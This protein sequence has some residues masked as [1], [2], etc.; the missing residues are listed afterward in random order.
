MI[1]LRSPWNPD[2]ENLG[3]PKM[4]ARMAGQVAVLTLTG[5]VAMSRQAVSRKIPATEGT[6]SLGI[7][8]R[9]NSVRAAKA[10]A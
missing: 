5:L 8:M 9:V 1:P 6:S 7:Y 4:I 2:E 3:W 10:L